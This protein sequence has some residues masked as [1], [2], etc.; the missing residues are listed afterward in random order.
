MVSGGERDLE[1]LGDPAGERWSAR[2][3]E[4]QAAL[5]RVAGGGPEHLYVGAS[6]ARRAL[7]LLL[8]A[9]H[10]RDPRVRPQ[11]PLD[12]PDAPA[13]PEQAMHAAVLLDLVRGALA[14]GRA[15]EQ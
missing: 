12:G 14:D 4:Q 15:V 2:P 9:E 11:D 5:D 1:R 3:P 6:P 8:R 7:E 10:G 13:R